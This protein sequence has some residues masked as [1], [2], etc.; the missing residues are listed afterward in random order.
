MWLWN[1]KV[2]LL[3]TRAALGAPPTQRA[4]CHTKGHVG[5]PKGQAASLGKENGKSRSEMKAWGKQKA[6]ERMGT[7]GEYSPI[8]HITHQAHPTSEAG[9]YIQIK[10]EKRFHLGNTAVRQQGWKVLPTGRTHYS[11]FHSTSAENRKNWE[12]RGREFTEALALWLGH[13]FPKQLPCVGEKHSG[14]T[15]KSTPLHSTSE[16]PVTMQHGTRKE[17]RSVCVYSS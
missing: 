12:A 8:R 3:R 5:F 17:R 2:S 4:A 11:N 16:L 7:W 1:N 10:Q 15:G 14:K 6:P 9:R 13:C